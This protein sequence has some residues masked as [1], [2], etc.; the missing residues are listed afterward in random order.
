M[1]KIRYEFFPAHL[2]SAHSEDTIAQNL[3][4]GQS[5]T[6]PLVRKFLKSGTIVDF[7]CGSGEMVFA[8]REAG[9]LSY[10]FDPSIDAVQYGKNRFHLGKHI[11]HDIAALPREVDAVL[12]SYVLQYVPHKEK[13]L[14]VLVSYIKPGGFLFIE[15]SNK[16]GCIRIYEWIRGAQRPRYEF[17]DIPQNSHLRFL[18]VFPNFPAYM[19]FSDKGLKKMCKKLFSFFERICYA[20]K[21]Y[22]AG[23]FFYVYQKQ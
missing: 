13:I 21:I 19:R 17:Y 20:C 15:K 12:C 1:Q 3:F 14:D 6:L 4:R 2:A 9:F 11:T 16:Y 10:G 22:I 5:Y 18:G 7:G 23:T 8:L